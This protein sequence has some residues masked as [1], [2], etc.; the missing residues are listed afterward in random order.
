[1]L[2]VLMD[3]MIAETASPNSLEEEQ[4][5]TAC[6]Q[7]TYTSLDDTNIKSLCIDSSSPITVI[8]SNELK[9]LIS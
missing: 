9:D 6:T 4:A 5:S 7:L 8:M 1:M 2:H 3:A